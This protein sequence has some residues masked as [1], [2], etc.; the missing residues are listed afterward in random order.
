MD[1]PLVI[2]TVALILAV[3]ALKPQT[4]TFTVERTGPSQ[5][6]IWHQGPGSVVVRRAFLHDAAGDHPLGEQVEVTD[7]D[8]WPLASPENPSFRRVK[9]EPHQRYFV[10]L[11]VNRQLVIRYWGKGLLGHFS[12]SK[13]LITESP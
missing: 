8:G 6:S 1:L 3:I 9:I 4:P 10:F 5:Y 7:E 13:V 12:R 2:G 11:N